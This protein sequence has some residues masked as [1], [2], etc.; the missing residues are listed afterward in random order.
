VR[1]MFCA[2]LIVTCV[3]FA[4]L[5]G[6]NAAG[7]DTL[8]VDTCE[9][10]TLLGPGEVVHSSDHYSVTLKLRLNTDEPVS[11]FLD[12]VELQA[13]EGGVWVPKE[14]APQ[15]IRPPRGDVDVL[16][17]PDV[18][19]GRLETD[20]CPHFLQVLLEV[21]LEGFDLAGGDR[22]T[23]PDDQF[24]EHDPGFASSR[25]SLIVR[26]NKLNPTTLD[27][28]AL[29]T[30]QGGGESGRTRMAIIV[31]WRSNPPPAY[32]YPLD[33]LSEG[34]YVVNVGKQSLAQGGADAKEM[35]L[36]PGEN[37]FTVDNPDTLPERPDA[38]KW[39]TSMRQDLAGLRESVDDHRR[40]I[41]VKYATR[42][43]VS[44]PEVSQEYEDSYL[45]LEEKVRLVSKDRACARQGK[46]RF[47]ASAGKDARWLIRLVQVAK[48][49]GLANLSFAVILIVGKV[50]DEA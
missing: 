50:Q 44:A 42:Q 37:Y 16:F 27:L 12:T 7:S 8:D 46:L 11:S 30:W 25:E 41:E 14:L 23:V 19:P 17:L 6:V 5:V 18:S 4:L 32:G 1:A 39:E 26:F 10:F 22:A 40:V 48:A 9:D 36:L 20:R 29:S 49:I 34:V 28:G 13:L 43:L 35:S 15:S 47:A 33:K 45:T 24:L 21:L 38:S 2:V 31:R 3:G